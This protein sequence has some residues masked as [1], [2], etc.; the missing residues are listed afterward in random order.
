VVLWPVLPSGFTPN[1]DGENDIFIIRGGP[2]TAVDFK[3]YNNWG[4]LIFSTTDINEGWDGTYMGE[5]APVGV[6]TWTYS[7]IVTPNREAIEKKGD[8]TL[9]R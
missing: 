7:V 9:M 8:V 6:Y 3:I 5:D 2:F 4:Q 1:N